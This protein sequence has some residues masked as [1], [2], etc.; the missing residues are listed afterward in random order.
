MGAELFET[1]LVKAS[2]LLSGDTGVALVRQ[3]DGRYQVQAALGL[4]RERFVNLD[5]AQEALYDL[6]FTIL[7]SAR[8]CEALLGEAICAAWGLERAL[9]LPLS[10]GHSVQ[11]VLLLSVIEIG[12]IKEAAEA[13]GKQMGIVLQHLSLRQK[14]ERQ[15]RDLALLDRVRSSFDGALRL[16]E[17]L[18]IALRATTD[19]FGYSRI[20]VYLFEEGKLKLRCAHGYEKETLDWLEPGA[21]VIGR[22]VASGEP[23]FVRDVKTDPDYIGADGEAISEI[24]VP[25]YCQKDIIGVLNVESTQASL[26]SADLQLV[27]LVARQLSL[28]TERTR[29]HEKALDS[30]RK[31][32]LLAENMH[33]VVSLHKPDGRLSYVSAS[34]EILTGYTTEHILKYHPYRFIHEADRAGLTLNAHENLPGG[35]APF[36]FRIQCASGESVWVE[37]TVQPVYSKTGELESWVSSTRDI[38][39]RRR[40]EQR[41]E[42]LAQHDPMTGLANRTLFMSRLEDVLQQK[43]QNPTKLSVLLFI[44]LDRFKVVNDSLGHAV[45]DALLAE[46]AQRLLESVRPGDTVARLGGDEF[47]VI[48]EE[49]R[50]NSEAKLIT[51]RILAAL[52]RPFR[53]QGHEVFSGASI[54]MAFINNAG[55]SANDALRNADVAMYEAKKAGGSDFA[56]FNENLY[57]GYKKRLDMETD[58]RH[59][60]EE[61]AFYLTYQPLFDFAKRRVMG[62]EALLRWR[63]PQLGLVPP[64]KFIPLAEESDLILEIDRWVVK[65]ACGQLANWTQRFDSAGELF[66]SINLSTRHLSVDNVAFKLS[67]MIGVMGVDPNRIKLEVTEGALLTNAEEGAAALAGLRSAGIKIQ[68][69][70]FGTGYSSLAYLH[71]LPLDSLK[72]DRSFVQRMGGG[73]QDEEIIKTVLALGSTLNLD[74]VAEGV[75]TPYQMQRL[76]DLGCT[77][78]Q[79]YLIAKPLEAHEIE[80]R[81][82]A[83]VAVPLKQL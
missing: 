69:D 14:A 18:R 49:L 83:N 56:V 26:T 13:F 5:V 79:G 3:D 68:L 7:D 25:I 36:V 19:V 24:A 8:D 76:S 21:G 38:S 10:F 75:E 78:G 6:D 20:G 41:L 30:E 9:V 37:T 58:L 46:L 32:R 28:A 52:K 35:Y 47:A 59:A 70:D 67:S 15:A 34:A 31:F 23:E 43:A 54:G 4:N 48:L 82:L 62:F 65:E 72:I 22:V 64:D 27:V 17:L 39:E 63:H 80:T 51:E 2:E 66:M 11:A 55:V 1:L 44:D 73:R 33:D 81:Y 77:Y 53:F 29:L 45:G 40:I 16:D 61:N 12:D 57:D 74:V 50:K 71:K 42:H 60:T